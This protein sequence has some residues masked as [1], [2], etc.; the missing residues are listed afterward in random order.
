MNKLNDF[1]A[2]V[3][4]VGL[5]R[6]NRYSV[7]MTPPPVLNLSNISGIGGSGRSRL[8]DLERMLLFC[9]QVQLPGLNLSTIQNR[10]FGEFREVPYEKLF[11]DLNMSF[12]VDQ[13]LYVKSVFDNWFAAIQNPITRSFSYYNDYVTTMEIIVEDLA[14]QERYSVTLYECYPKSISPVQMDY[15]S[16]D[17]MKLNVTMQYKYWTSSAMEQEG[18]EDFT[19]IMNS[20]KQYLVPE[21]YYNDFASFQQQVFTDGINSLSSQLG[22]PIKF[23]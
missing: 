13:N 8:S 18:G 9:D 14:D 15:A 12:Y 1:I 2:S 3:K 17:I 7:V 19:N 11:G 10:S 16:K 23:T 21:S 20:D 22:I 4:T 5:A 6:T